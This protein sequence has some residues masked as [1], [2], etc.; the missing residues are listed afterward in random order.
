[1]R[2]HVVRASRVV[3]L[4]V[5]VAFILW[6][7][8]A[9][10]GH[11]N[12]LDR[13]LAAPDLDPRGTLGQILSAIAIVTTPVVLTTIALGIAVWAYQRRLR[14][15]AGALTAAAL[16]GWGIA[17]VLKRLLGR[18]RPESAFADAITYSGA[19]YPSTHLVSAVILASTIVTIATAARRSTGRIWLI[20][21][22]GGAFVVLIGLDRWLM[23]HHYVSDIIG[24]ALLGATVLLVTLMAAGVHTVAESM[25]LVEEPAEYVDKQAAIIYNPAKVTDF[26]MFRKRVEYELRTRGWKPPLW[27]ETTQDDVGHQMVRDARDKDVDLVLVAG[28]DGTVRTVC[29][30]LVGTGI[31]V[32]LIPA[33]TGNL[34]ARNLGVSLDEQEAFRIAFDGQAQPV[35]VVRFTTDEQSEHFVVMSGIGADAQL[36]AS[37]NSDLKKLVGSAAYFLAAAQQIGSKPFDVRV[38]LDGGEPVDRRAMVALVGNVG[39]LQGGIK[40]FPNASASDGQLDVLI[41]N[42]TSVTDW[43]KVATGLLGGNDVE[44]LEYAQGTHVVLEVSEPVAYQ[45]DGDAEGETRRFEA[46]VVPDGLLVMLK[47]EAG[48]EH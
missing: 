24:G 30:E 6:T 38:T 10:S 19:S 46:E 3:P 47:P 1:M 48:S 36:I 32:G 43:A 34:L 2:E 12:G 42:P 8:L 41:G 28:G 5:T 23:R 31:P 40:I 13:A 9:V 33:G 16:G 26:D 37:T 4:A 45:L 15:L 44:P 20:R 39:T 25:G 11:L 17:W 18:A 21:L 7:A 14:R 22:A 27:L 35:D 29:S